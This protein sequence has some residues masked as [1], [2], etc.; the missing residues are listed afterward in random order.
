MK[1]SLTK[2]CPCCQ[3]TKALSGFYKHKATKDGLSCWCKICIKQG[4]KNKRHKDIE[5]YNK[6]QRDYRKKH[7]DK[8]KKWD[9]TKHLKQY[10]L[11]SEKWE[12]K[13]N[14]QKG[15]CAICGKH[16]SELKQ[17][18]NVDHNHSTGKTRDLLCTRCNN[19]VGKIE[20]NFELLETVLNYLK[21]HNGISSNNSR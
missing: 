15:C 18:L 14:K 11:T 17:T 6:R 21:K 13:F 7:P 8:T 1:L 12:N 10:N 2:I 19:L 16:Q 4:E 20:N 5:K 3:E 9:R